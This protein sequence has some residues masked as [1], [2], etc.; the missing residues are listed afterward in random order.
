MT[1]ECVFCGM[2]ENEFHTLVFDENISGDG[3]WYHE[4]CKQSE[5]MSGDEDEK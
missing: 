2:E 4:T 3:S 5:I 1:K